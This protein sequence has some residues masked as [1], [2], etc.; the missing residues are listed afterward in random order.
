MISSEKKIILTT[1]ESSKTADYSR[2]ASVTDI[3]PWS[4][5]QPGSRM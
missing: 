2:N 5:S 3:A 4:R 1:G